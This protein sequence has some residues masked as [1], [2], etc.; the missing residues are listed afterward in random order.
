VI[1]DTDEDCDEM[2]WVTH[3]DDLDADAPQDDIQAK[4][5]IVI[6]KETDSG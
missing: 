6:R 4:K 2:A 3:D 5:V 1:C